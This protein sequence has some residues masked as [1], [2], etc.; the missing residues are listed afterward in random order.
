MK[1]QEIEILLIKYT[2]KKVQKSIDSLEEDFRALEE[3]L[4]RQD[5]I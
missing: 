3:L 1:D 5:S 2:L 4:K